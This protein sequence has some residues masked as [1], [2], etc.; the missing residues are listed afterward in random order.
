MCTLLTVRRSAATRSRSDVRSRTS[1]NS[2]DVMAAQI[3]LNPEAPRKPCKLND[4]LLNLLGF[5]ECSGCLN[6]AEIQSFKPAQVGI[7]TSCRQN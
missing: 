5:C 4:L 2:S 1:I 7:L 6:S 3:Q